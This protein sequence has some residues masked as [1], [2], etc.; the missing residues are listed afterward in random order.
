MGRRVAVAAV[1][2]LTGV[3]FVLTAPSDSPLETTPP[4]AIPPPSSSTTTSTT[5]PR[6]STAKEPPARLSAALP[7]GT[8]FVVIV[9]PARSEDVT[10]ISAGIMMELEE[11]PV[12]AGT[13]VFHL[14]TP[15]DE[16]AYQYGHYGIPA[17]GI[18]VTINFNPEVLEA[19]G[20]DAEAI[21]RDSVRGSV[22]AGYPT[23]LL[24][25][26][27]RWA[28]DTE[29]PLQMEVTFET[30]A[31]RRG[32]DDL[33][34]ACSAFGGVQVIPVDRLWS[35]APPWDG[36]QVWIESQA[37][38][39]V[40][41]PSY[42]D[43]GPLSFRAYP[44]VLWTGTEMIVWG[45]RFEGIPRPGL[46]DGA[47]YAPDSDEWRRLAAAR[48][49]EGTPTR[50][51]WADDQM[52]VVSPEATLAYDPEA[53]TWTEVG[54]GQAPPTTPGRMVWTGDAVC[55]WGAELACLD[56]ASGEW[57]RL[58]EPPFQVGHQQWARGLTLFEGDLLAVG[59]PGTCKGLSLALWEGENWLTLPAPDFRGQ[60]LADCVTPRQVV[61]VG[62][63][64]LAWY[65][66]FE[67]VALTAGSSEWVSMG[68]PS[69]EGTEGASGAVVLG[70]RVLIPEYGEA[71]LYDPAA[72]T[73]S[74]V[75]LPGWGTDWEMIW[76]GEEVLMW[77][78]TQCCPGAGAKVDAWRWRPP[79][80]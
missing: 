79:Q 8:T 13:V 52:I 20:P 30:F 66:G 77:G 6:P 5:T 9:D 33:A 57:I 44:D 72:G 2:V 62:D 27:F 1:V 56:L 58:P 74:R 46:V 31:V 53:D 64:I 40:S 51:V 17:A 48:L 54:P 16:Y 21:I 10:D 19:L 15:A 49:P 25:P 4:E 18:L 78:A 41:H 71:A 55:L 67:A 61:V 47:A 68:Q 7:D 37:L 43:P 28:T 50:A 65:D 35:G 70:D 22:A 38:R 75:R 24:E 69:L 42:V 59:T 34:V 14:L 23:L 11:G 29:L 76:T 12:P 32:C 36:A 26:P 60:A 63:S 45:G 3:L 80:P 39:P 73:W